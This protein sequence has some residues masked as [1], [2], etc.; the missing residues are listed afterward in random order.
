MG[1]LPGDPA[2]HLPSEACCAM[3]ASTGTALSAA[4]DEAAPGEATASVT[5]CNERGL[6]ARAAARLVKTLEPYEAEVDVIY[7]GERVSGRSIMG[8]LMLGA[9]PGSPLDL[10][11]SGTQ[12]DSAL[13]AVRSLIARGFDEE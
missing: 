6:H 2:L 7:R 11:A 8:L 1:T 5:V 3:T 13:E 9:G 4:S 10:A 12:A